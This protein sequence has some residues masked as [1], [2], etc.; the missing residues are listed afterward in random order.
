MVIGPEPARSLSSLLFN[1]YSN[2]LGVALPR[3][4]VTALNDFLPDN[5]VGFAAIRTTTRFR[6][7][8]RSTAYQSSLI[9]SDVSR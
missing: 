9:H 5:D 8:G 3:D 2:S 6:F 7:D 4:L 1:V